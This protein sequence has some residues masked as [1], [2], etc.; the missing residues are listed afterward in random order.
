MIKVLVTGAGGQLG[1]E[2]RALEHHYP[3][4]AF[5]FYD[6]EGLP[7]DQ[8]S[9][10]RHVF[11][12]IQPQVVINAA[13]YTA[14]D[15]AESERELA[16]M[17]NATA[18]EMLAENCAANNAL[19]IHVSTDY[20]FDGKGSAPYKET[21]PVFPL[22]VYGASKLRGERLAFGKSNRVVIVR[23]SWV[24]SYFGK[25]FVKTMLR[26]LRE[27]ETIGV[28]SDQVGRP[29]Y[30]ADLAAALLDITLQYAGLP[31]AGRQTDPRFNAVYHYADRGV[32]SWFDLAKKI[33]ELIH[34][35]CTVRAIGTAEY[36][37]PAERPA[38]S[39]LDTAAIE[40]AF[41]LSIPS[42]EDSLRVCL[43]KF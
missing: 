10:L 7:V 16:F 2:I 12:E 11:E 1:S 24:Y 38:Y 25:N 23:T 18:V 42:W 8:P 35:S 39:V 15:K 26:L 27:K 6:R 34:S 5:H 32:I 28:V 40:A 33:G 19:L 9:R 3:T 30:A 20:V 22:G 31:T 17:I 14:V 13:A 41:G 37:T 36:P 29:T 4:M 43:S 21:D